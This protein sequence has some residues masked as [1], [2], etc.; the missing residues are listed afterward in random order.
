MEEKG[1]RL[2]M[3]TLEKG[4]NGICKPSFLILEI[5]FCLCYWALM[6]ETQNQ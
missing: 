1:L 6:L 2:G 3:G 4:N 5:D